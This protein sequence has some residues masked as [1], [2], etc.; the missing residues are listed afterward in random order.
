MNALKIPVTRKQKE[1]KCT[2]ASMYHKVD[3]VLTWLMKT[4]TLTM[5]PEVSFLSSQMV[6]TKFLVQSAPV[7]PAPHSTRYLSLVY[8]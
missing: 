7:D 5:K 3:S 4:L 2:I 6:R 1:V 8:T